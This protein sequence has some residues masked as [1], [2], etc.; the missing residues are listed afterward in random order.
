MSEMKQLEE[1]TKVEKIRQKQDELNI[2][3]E[4]LR[5]EAKVDGYWVIRSYFLQTFV[6]TLHIVILV[7]EGNDMPINSFAELSLLVFWISIIRTIALQS[8]ELSTIRER[9]GVIRTL[10][11]LGFLDRDD[12]GEGGKKKTKKK[13]IFPR[14][15]ELFERVGKTETKEYQPA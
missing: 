13:S 4:A 15:K 10:E 6:F 3:L 11:I 14:F 9:F 1:N 2:Y 12:E 7:L 5:Q 8:K